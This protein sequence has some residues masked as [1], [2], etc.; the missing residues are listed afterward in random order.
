MTFLKLV[1]LLGLIGLA[2]PILIHLLNRRQAK[3][4]DWGAMQFLLA[5]LT[6]R[7]RHIMIEEIILMAIRCLLLALLVLAMARPF[8]PSRSVIPWAIVLPS[9][10]AAALAMGIATAMWT[11]IRLR[12]LLIW[13][14]AVLFAIA[15]IATA[16][17]YWA[18]TRMWKSAGGEKDVVLVLDGSASMTMALKGETNF[19]RAVAEAR[20]VAQSCK[21]GDAL[22]IIVAG[23]APRRVVANPTSDRQEVAAALDQAK[24]VGG[25]MDVLKALNAATAS[26][27]EG[28]NP[29]KK[30]VLLT[31]GQ[32]LGWDLDNNSSWNFLAAGIDAMPAKAQF[33]CRTLELPERFRNL[34][35]AG[36]TL[37]RQVVGT[38]RPVRISVKVANT[39]TDPIPATTVKLSINNEM[40][41]PR[42]LENIP[43]GAAE[44]VHFLH[45]FDR[46]GPS[47]LKAE[48]LA[49][50]V[51]QA[52]NVAKRVINVIDRLRV[53]IIDGATGDQRMSGATLVRIALAPGADA[54]RARPRDRKGRRLIVEPLVVPATDLRSAAELHR[55]CPHLWRCGLIV[56]SNVPRLPASV[57]GEILRFVRRGGGLLI[58]PG[59]FAQLRDAKKAGAT[60]QAF[61]LGWKTETA[62]MVLP[63]ELLK[64]VTVP[65][66]AARA[67]TKTFSHPSLAL[68]SDP[69]RSDMPQLRIKSYWQLKANEADPSVRVA[70]LMDTGAPLLVERKLPNAKGYVLM[71][72][73]AM[74]LHDSNLPL[75]KCFVPLMHELSYFLATPV[76]T[77]ANV[78]PGTEVALELDP[79]ADTAGVQDGPRTAKVV[80][81][82][83][84]QGTASLSYASRAPS[85]PGPIA[86][87]CPTAWLGSTRPWARTPARR[88]SCPS[89]C[90]TTPT[91]AAFS[92]WR[93]GT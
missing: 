42:R 38:D 5:S 9:V 32:K 62:Q 55:K 64:R 8:L 89:W 13:V 16:K 75:L 82:G 25:S 66:N 93:S 41:V 65:D 67:A 40:L 30:I 33:I 54:R 34:S 19:E 47:L 12:W 61:Y 18:Q 43:P 52:D 77:D 78:E 69:A 79:L 24:P 80:T 15:A 57:T 72:A 36:I 21:P 26:L 45:H 31:D 29:G 70:G 11:M 7:K 56:L 85:S 4:V 48:V 92:P 20:A 39:G 51:I 44:T 63:A 84:G 71:S 23:S 10:L 1:M 58:L 2:S 60:P 81:P 46:P 50:D 22:S 88:A 3:L 87:A 91:R 35:A 73:M 49:K 90:S 28:H 27:A 74:N 17:E 83:G 14:A 6:T 59:D 53:L 76:M 68:V 37:S 86:C